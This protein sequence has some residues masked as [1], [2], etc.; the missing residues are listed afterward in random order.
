[1][2]LFCDGLYTGDDDRAETQSDRAERLTREVLYDNVLALYQGHTEARKKKVADREKAK[3]EEEQLQIAGKSSRDAAMGRMAEH[4]HFSDVSD[5]DVDSGENVKQKRARERRETRRM[6]NAV[7][8]SRMMQ[9]AFEPL[10]KVMRQSN[11]QNARAARQELKFRK[12]QARI[13]TKLTGIMCMIMGKDSL[14]AGTKQALCD[15]TKSDDD[16][17]DSSSESSES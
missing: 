4:M 16:E 8:K 2:V 11:K 17:S 15:L 1:M 7:Q 6:T 9:N 10:C 5:A 14:S 3:H 12:K 13:D